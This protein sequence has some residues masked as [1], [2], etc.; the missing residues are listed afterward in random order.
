[1]TTKRKTAGKTAK[2]RAA[3]RNVTRKG[4]RTRR[5]IVLTIDGERY[6]RLERVARAMNETSWCDND[7][8]PETVFDAF[9]WPLAEDF[10]DS[11]DKLCG[12]ISDGIATSDD[13]LTDAPEPVHAARLDELNRAFADVL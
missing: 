4:N 10:L 2:K 7:N 6:A 8:T 1:M 5:R 11:T 12:L 13:G 9:V 3:G